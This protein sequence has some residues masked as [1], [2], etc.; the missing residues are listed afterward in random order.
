MSMH[1]PSSFGRL[2]DLAEQEEASDGV[3]ND[4]PSPTVSTHTVIQRYR[5]LNKERV[6]SVLQS[7][8][9][10]RDLV[11][12]INVKRCTEMWFF[13]FLCGWDCYSLQD[14]SFLLCLL[15]K[16]FQDFA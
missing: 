16:C 5:F 2:H 12:A 1:T 8:W 6:Q 9:D 3:S 13:V 11:Q 4:A 15:F 7:G 14:V 10:L